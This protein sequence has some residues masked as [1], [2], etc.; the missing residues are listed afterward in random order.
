M[1]GTLTLQ[2]QNSAVSITSCHGVSGDIKTHEGSTNADTV[3]GLFTDGPCGH[4]LTVTTTQGDICVLCTLNKLEEDKDRLRR[5]LET[6]AEALHKAEGDLEV[7]RSI[8]HTAMSKLSRATDRVAVLEQTV[9][10]N[11]EKLAELLLSQA[12]MARS[13]SLH[14]RSLESRHATLRSELDTAQQLLGDAEVDTQHWRTK[15][16]MQNDQHKSHTSALDS[17]IRYLQAEN[18]ELLT[19]VTTLRERCGS[20]D[21][22]LAQMNASYEVARTN[23]LNLEW[24]LDEETR[25]LISERN[26]WEADF[27]AL[28]EGIQSAP[29]VYLVPQVMA[30]I[31]NLVILSLVA[32]AVRSTGGSTCRYVSGVVPV[33]ILMMR[34]VFL[35]MPS[36]TGAVRA[37]V[38]HEMPNE[39][40]ISAT[41][42][43]PYDLGITVISP[44]LRRPVY[45]H[46]YEA[47]SPIGLLARPRILPLDS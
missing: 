47:R 16:E 31:E 44:I 32:L 25:R 33:A 39:G 45:P 40:R 4:G 3:D 9:L 10:E 42:L 15:Y 8:A 14:A 20:L 19:E 11:E 21:D 26:D 2:E 29:A 17:E 38:S 24:R 28:R 1:S 34:Q 43:H 18:V 23:C 27:E 6:T 7:Q 46:L 37:P 30:I 22:H 41:S 35:A 36:A 12:E 5:E 13:R